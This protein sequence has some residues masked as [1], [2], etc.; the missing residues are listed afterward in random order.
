VA[1]SRTGDLLVASLW[2]GNEL[3]LQEVPLEGWSLSWDADRQIQ[4]QGT[5]QV[6][7]TDGTLAPW[8]NSDRLGAWGSRLELTWVSGT[9]GTR[10]PM[11]GWRIRRTD[12][13]STPIR[14]T[15]D[16]VLVAL[17]P[18]LLQVRADHAALIAVDFDRLDGEGAPQRPTV[19]A[20]VRRLVGARCAVTTAPGVED[21]RAPRGLTYQESRLDAID[22][23]LD[24]IGAAYRVTASGGMEI[25]PRSGTA[26]ALVLAPGDD[27]VLIDLRRSV[28][29]EGL[30]NAGVS[31]G[32]DATGA[33]LIGRWN[34][35]EGPY[36]VSGPGGRRPVFHQSVS[37]SNSGLV[38]DARAAVESCLD[39]EVVFRVEC[40]FDPRVQVHDLVTV[41][42]P[43]PSGPADLTGRVVSVDMASMSEVATPSVSMSLNVAFGTA[44][45]SFLSRIVE[46]WK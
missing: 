18:S 12:V 45:V 2:R 40:L 14:I 19:L 20:E 27:G 35:T 23:L 17:P 44:Q 42:V 7:D 22:D 29:D 38:A 6:A 43:M 8:V 16:G 3:I 39:A 32:E 9:S 5:F 26:T 30:Y 13:P 25:V 28:S 37:K 10:I 24:V 46:A 41:R 4:G 11:E 15:G 36:A 33:P 21:S 31:N 1:G 34:L